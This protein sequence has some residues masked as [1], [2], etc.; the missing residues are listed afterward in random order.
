MASSWKEFIG[1]RVKIVFD[2][3][4]QIAIKEGTLLNATKEYIMI[5]SKDTEEAIS[6]NRLVRIELL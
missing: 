5:K 3:G 6:T 1:K 2:D 4:R